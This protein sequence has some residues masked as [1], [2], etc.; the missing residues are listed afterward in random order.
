MKNKKIII[1]IIGISILIGICYFIGGQDLDK[2]SNQQNS[3][4]NSTENNIENKNEEEYLRNE[5]FGD[6]EGKNNPYFQNEKTIRKFVL[7]YNQNAKSKITKVEWHK[8]HQI[9]NVKFDDFSAKLNSSSNVGFLV[10]FEF[11]NGKAIIGQYKE[12]IKELIYVFDSDLAEEKFNEAFNNANINQYTSV[13]VT[14]NI[15]ITMHY[16]EN[17]VGYLSGDRYFID[18]SCSDYNK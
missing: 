6:K 8:N 15:S 9:A 7:E 5:L 12:I 2:I 10:E 16:N 3:I 4:P 14:N 11:T 18:I 1:I 17:Q 13:N